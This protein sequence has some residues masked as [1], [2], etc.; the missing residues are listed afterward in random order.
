MSVAVVQ[1]YFKNTNVWT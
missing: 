1:C